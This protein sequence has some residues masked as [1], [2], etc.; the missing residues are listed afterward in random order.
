MKTPKVKKLKQVTPKRGCGSD[1]LLPFYYRLF[2]CATDVLI[3]SFVPIHKWYCVDCK[4]EFDIESNTET[5]WKNKF[6]VLTSDN[7]K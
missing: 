1:N 3:G 6:A 7:R 4:S 2:G 5:I